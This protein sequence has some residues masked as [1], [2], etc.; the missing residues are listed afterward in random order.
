MPPRDK[1]HPQNKH[2][3]RTMLSLR[4]IPLALLLAASIIVGMAACDSVPVSYAYRSTPVNGWEPKDT[5]SFPID[6][7]GRTGRYA[8]SVGVRTT[9]LFP[10]QSLWLV[11]KQQWH[12]TSAGKLDT[13]VCRFTNTTGDPANHGLSLNQFEF[14]FD[15]LHLQ[16][17]DRGHITVRHIMRRDILPGVSDIGIIMREID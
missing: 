8:M 2:M 10:F 7:I 5:L 12:Q 14:P 17:G 9:A 6:T 16:R 4:R 3:H 11:V 15:T 1:E 13:V